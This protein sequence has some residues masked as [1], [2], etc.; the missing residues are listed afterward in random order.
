VSAL[1]N[2]QRTFSRFLLTGNEEGLD[3]S[4]MA[5]KGPGSL[6]ARDL[7]AIYRNNVAISLRETLEKT[8]PAALALVGDEFFAFW[9]RKFIAA[10]P[11]VQPVL[12]WYGKDFPAF[13]GRLKGLATFPYVAD[14]ARLEW[15]LNIAATGL[16]GEAIEEAEFELAIAGEGLVILSPSVSL[17]K[18]VYAIIDIRRYALGEI[19]ETPSFGTGDEQ[20]YAVYS[21]AGNIEIYLVTRTTFEILTKIQAG[22]TLSA[23]LADPIPHSVQATVIR[24]IGHLFSKGIFTKPHIGGN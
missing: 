23:V 13:L 14:V 17:L 1:E 5:P 8:F 2:F 10:H 18:S 15:A 12:V 24:E 9:A 4:L 20:F 22:D 3:Q 21:R 7:A 11:P 6:T 19:S 16:K